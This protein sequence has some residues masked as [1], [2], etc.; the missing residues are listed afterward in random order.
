MNNLYLEKIRNNLKTVSKYFDPTKSSY[1]ILMG[2]IKGRTAEEMIKG[3]LTLGNNKDFPNEFR[4][5]FYNT[6]KMLDML[7]VMD[8]E[9]INKQQKINE[10]YEAIKNEFHDR[11]IDY[12]SSFK[13]NNDYEKMSYSQKKDYL[14]KLD[15]QL[16]L[17]DNA[18]QNG[19]NKEKKSGQ[20]FDENINDLSFAEETNTEKGKVDAIQN[21]ASSNVKIVV[22]PSANDVI[23][24]IN[25]YRENQNNDS[26]FFFNIDYSNNGV[27]L[28]IGFKGNKVNEKEPLFKCIYNNMEYFNKEIRPTLIE[29]HVLDGDVSSRV[30][31][32]TFE[33]K[34]ETGETMSATGDPN[35][36]LDTSYELNNYVDSRSNTRKNKNVRVRKLEVPDYM[37]HAAFV[38]NSAFIILVFGVVVIL[39]IC[40]FIFIK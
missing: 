27:T 15:K 24:I 18:L 19:I 40:L 32:G 7:I 26:K 29:E 11:K 6:Y 2:C 8:K 38:N 12:N 3:L 34:N 21:N 14:E 37:K 23:G 25:Y 9:I 30:E 31:N 16:K 13:M 36:V 1:A 10:N 5:F 20:S 35:A 39:I 4:E 17:V 33:S 28:D 22:S